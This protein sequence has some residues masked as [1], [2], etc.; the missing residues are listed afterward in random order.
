M[1][2]HLAGSDLFPR[3][4]VER[5]GPTGRPVRSLAVG[6]VAITLW[7]STGAAA[8]DHAPGADA[9]TVGAS[10]SALEYAP[11][12]DVYLVSRT[13][14]GASGDPS[15]TPDGQRVAFVSNARDLAGG[16]GTGIPSIFLATASTRSSDPF[17]GAPQ[18][19]SAPD[20]SLPQV[21]ADGPS[22]DPVVSADGRYVA[23]V[24]SAGNLVPVSAA[25]TGVYVRDLVEGTTV[26]LDVGAEAG[27]VS[28][29]PDMSDDG[30]YVAFAS[31][32]VALT[33]GDVN[34][35]PDVFV[36]DLDAD[37]NGT[38]GDVSVTRV[39][40]A[41]TVAGGLSEPA[42]SAD[43]E[44]IVATA[45]VSDPSSA[46]P[47]PHL[48]R[49]HRQTGATETVLAGTRAGAVDATGRVVAGITA[50]CAGSPTVVAATLD[51]GDRWFAVG[52]G[53]PLDAAAAPVVSADGSRVAYVGAP[54]T[55]ADADV[56]PAVRIAAPRWSA[57]APAEAACPPE[58][59][60]VTVVGPG[61]SAALSASGRTVALAGAGDMSLAA[62]SVVAVD[63]HT[64]D[65]LA[66]ANT[67]RSGAVPR[68][69]T[70]A[71]I[72][73]VS[74]AELLAGAGAL[75]RL[76]LG[77]L[78]D[79]EPAGLGPALSGLPLDR[80]PL[81][82]SVLADLP[83]RIAELPGGWH[84]LLPATPF[85]DDVAENITLASIVAW[86]SSSEGSAATG[87][88]GAAAADVRGLRLGDISF[89]ETSVGRLTAATLLLGDV[90]LT[91][92]TIDGTGDTLDRWRAAVGAQGVD[93]DVTEQTVL[94]EADA[95]GV[96]LG[97]IGL[98]DI[99]VADV[100]SATDASGSTVGEALF[101]LV[102]AGDLPWEALDPA[103]LPTD[104]STQVSHGD[105]ADDG[106][107]GT[108]RFRFT[109]DPGPG[110]PTR[111]TDA[112]ASVHLP[113]TTSPTAVL[114]GRAGP[115]STSA[116]QPYTGT[117]TVDGSAVQL[118]LG[119]GTGGTSVSV[120]VDYTASRGLG[121]WVTTASLTADGLVAREV[122]GPAPSTTD[123]AAS[124]IG[125]GA[126]SAEPRTA[127]VL[128]ETTVRYDVLRSPGPGT[129]G[130]G[131]TGGEA[132]Y[133]IAPPAAGQRVQVAAGSDDLKLTVTLLEPA[134]DTTPLGVAV[135]RDAPSRAIPGD[136]G[137]AIGSGF[138][139][140][141][142]GYDMVDAARSSVGGTAVVG[143]RWSDVDGEAAWLVRVTGEGAAAGF[144]R[145]RVDYSDEDPLP[146]CTPW[147][148]PPTTG[149]D[150]FGGSGSI[151]QLD[152][153]GSL[154][155]FDP[156]DFADPLEPDADVEASA[157]PT[158]DEVTASTNTVF[159]TDFARM[160][161]LHGREG[162]DE[163]LASIR[164]LDG[165]GAVGDGAVK[166]AVL[167]VDAD[168][169][170]IAA[171][172]ALDA[173]P[174]SL[175][176]RQ[177]VV[178]EINRYVTAAIGAQREHIAAIVIVGGDD[179]I[180]HAPLAMGAGTVAETGHAG[181]LR[182]TDD[183]G[184]RCAAVAAGLIDPCAT[185]QSAAAAGGFL[186]SDDPYALADA[187]PSLGGHLYAPTVGIGRLIDAPDE[188]RAQLDRFR[189][190]EGV[191]EADSLLAAGYGP[192]SDLPE[193]LSAALSWR[194]GEGDTVLE[195]GWTTA[196]A[197]AALAPDEGDAP[198]IIALTAVG[199][200]SRM[201]SAASA[202]DEATEDAA[203]DAD[204]HRPAPP[205]AADEVFDPFAPA[206]EFQGALVLAL[207]CHSG[208]HVPESVSP[209]EADWASTF[210]GAGAFIGSTG[211]A[212]ADETTRGPSERLLA[213]FG[214]WIGVR[215]E[216]GPVS[217]GSALTYAKQSLLAQAAQYTADDERAIAQTVFYGVPLYTFR[218]SSMPAPLA[219]PASVDDDGTGAIH[220]SPSL[221]TV[222]LTDP[223][224][225]SRSFLSADGMDP[226]SVTGQALLPVV[227]R[228][229]P[230]EAAGTV[231]RGVLVTGLR[232]EWREPV[233]PAVAEPHTG[234][235]RSASD[236][237]TP[238]PPSAA[239]VATLTHQVGPDGAS[240]VVVA[241]AARVSTDSSGRFRFET[242]SDLE[243]EVLYG[244]AGDAVAPVIARVTAASTFRAVAVDPSA[245]GEV[246][247]A[248][249]LVASRGTD[250][251]PHV[252]QP[253]ELMPGEGDV[254]SGA[255]PTDVGSDYRWILQVVDEAGNVT[256]AHSD[257][258]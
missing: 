137:L 83:L 232:S 81:G 87:E 171:R 35:A 240:A 80:L 99:P 220:L 160:R 168:P 7:A 238:A 73:G 165:V 184:E 54:E 50:D 129:D 143:A 136:P 90:P 1:T 169:G 243:L 68:Y 40:A 49:I 202:A 86:A 57:S 128:T 85:A 144:S 183:S 29:H 192:W 180:P 115:E 152:P 34:G 41:R 247:R 219:Q 13:D 236:F 12:S 248:L 187:S 190:S 66:V 104:V 47:T 170:V 46:T 253:V 166:G 188:I 72:A 149:P 256:T 33:A 162:V 172:A 210:S 117:V 198:S 145:V 127:P 147:I 51:D 82:A 175:P 120:T 17:A 10:A 233:E 42:L 135:R 9:V 109:F 22:G 155:T 194:T 218:D 215:G 107:G 61:E 78:H 97:A 250:D 173:D 48:L 112:A 32:S 181:A 134:A 91:A 45:Q 64:H 92:L 70:A 59:A 234:A 103:L 133:R 126:R 225:V 36:A 94:A 157:M 113:A 246:A 123:A 154:D 60:D 139:P 130:R 208:V 77:R 20:R 95:A 216:G 257:A 110:E 254:W 222:T 37:G 201:V 25:G 231:A 106:C 179:V 176:A 18:L 207:G 4:L 63:L 5:G 196:D 229:V 6:V 138:G 75:A 159:I 153:Y 193:A 43:G 31:D 39:P 102:P 211:C 11:G 209:D 58:A 186:L 84:D 28:W 53:V 191:L 79:L 111:F 189:W 74:G 151:D 163:V 2:A 150:E 62:H 237:S 199:D 108:A 200:R 118:P 71:D 101:A 230:Y 251:A 241:T 142:D 156:F 30:R 252:W 226:L 132:W 146:R 52:I 235:S 19:V 214:G 195:P 255:V 217:V 100:P 140:A 114:V 121:D 98:E 15:I 14:L 161:D 206:A 197:E 239:T 182:L 213:L 185:P 158:S 141:V 177:S 69:V 131:T 224:G 88:E 245:S 89:S 3:P 93:L 228:A 221:A 23:F 124:P 65:G 55:D 8:A 76:E 258:G 105:C 227:T 164:A 203:L 167:T 38:R 205:P 27:A 212:L 21:P 67:M 174:C 223:A 122:V 148:A 24:S 204:D 125:D 178:K 44:W 119:D 16:E 96:D 56:G 244:D 116:E 26:R 242:Y 249:L